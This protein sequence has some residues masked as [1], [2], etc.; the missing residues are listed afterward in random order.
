MS[1]VVPFPPLPP[2]PQ[3]P[4]GPEDERQQTFAR[5]VGNITGALFSEGETRIGNTATGF[6]ASAV[7]LGQLQA[8]M[9]D[10]IATWDM[11]QVRARWEEDLFKWV[12][13]LLRGWV[14]RPKHMQFDIDDD[15][16]IR[17]RL[18]TQDNRGYYHYQ[19]DVFPGRRRPKD[20]RRQ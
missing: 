14:Q 9:E 6:R 12:H 17:I 7:D 16:G 10:A 19:F 18:E 1:E 8:M 2:V 5:I 11:E 20:A 4:V 3:P 13:R 15:E